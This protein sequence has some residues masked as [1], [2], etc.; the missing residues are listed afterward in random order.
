MNRRACCA[1]PRFFQ[2]QPQQLS[3]ATNL[4]SASAAFLLL[5][6]IALFTAS[7]CAVH[8]DEHE[9]CMGHPFSD[10]KNTVEWIADST[11][12][13]RVSK[14][15]AS[16]VPNFQVNLGVLPP[17]PSEAVTPQQPHKR[18]FLQI[19]PPNNAGK[20]S[21]SCTQTRQQLLSIT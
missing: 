5:S 19:S 8:R 17:L 18:L 12:K 20:P 21:E 7:S 6:L 4:M 2:T 1:Q 15:V 14:R 16:P 10:S 13:S 9:V 3:V 11:L